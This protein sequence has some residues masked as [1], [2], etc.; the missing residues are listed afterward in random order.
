[1]NH[2]TPRQDME[3]WLDLQNNKVRRNVR[4][5]TPSEVGQDYLLH[6]SIDTN[7]K[8][9][10]PRIG[11]SQSPSEDRTVPRIT[12]A[13][14]LL[15]CLIGNGNAVDH[16]LNLKS[17]GLPEDRHYKGG[18]KIYALPFECALKPTGRL[19]YD[20]AHSDEY[21]LVSYSPETVSYQPEV[22]GKAFYQ[23]ITFRPRAGQRTLSDGT[24][25]VEVTR[26]T[27]LRFSQH[28]FLTQGYWRIEGPTD[29]HASLTVSD[30]GFQVSQ[31]DKAE[32]NS[33][34]NASAALLG[35]E[36]PSYMSW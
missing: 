7:V 8:T 26:P 30:R 11:S 20:Q 13:P 25:F 6:V 24:L 15:G 12:V 22:A 3:D 29:R 28:I 23:E 27:G 2:H 5:V 21:W 9:F 35:L 32:Y 34:K 4:I 1:M 19:V 14:S 17:T 16:F 33:V 36:E 10:V 31:I 18:W